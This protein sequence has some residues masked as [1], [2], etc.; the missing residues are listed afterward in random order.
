[1][2]ERGWAYNYKKRIEL[3]GAGFAIG[4]RLENTGEKTIDINHY[5]HNFTS[6]DGV[7][8]GPDYSV[9]FPFAAKEPKSRGLLEK[10]EQ[11]GPDFPVNN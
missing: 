7:P 11:I 4:H 3:D 10:S 5:N 2:G 9:I 6:I 1:M 8:Y